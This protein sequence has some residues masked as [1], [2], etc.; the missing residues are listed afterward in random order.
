MRACMCVREGGREEGR[1]RAAER[2]RE[3]V[4]SRVQDVSQVDQR[5]PW[6]ARTSMRLWVL[7]GVMATNNRFKDKLVYF[8]FNL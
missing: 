3:R 8:T 7:R 4:H 5:G 1:G 2:E 6:A